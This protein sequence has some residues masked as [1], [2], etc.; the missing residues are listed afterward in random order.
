MRL[1]G[2]WGVYLRMSSSY[3]FVCSRAVGNMRRPRER[4][5]ATDDDRCVRLRIRQE[6]GRVRSRG[7]GRSR[8]RFLPIAPRCPWPGAGAHS[9]VR[10]DSP[11]ACGSSGSRSFSRDEASHVP[12]RTHAWDVGRSARRPQSHWGPAEPVNTRWRYTLSATAARATAGSRATRNAR[13]AGDG[14]AA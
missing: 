7:P 2:D 4:P 10:L 12:M 11:A 1:V 8:P 3:V 6:T 9:G 13:A 5:V 14:G